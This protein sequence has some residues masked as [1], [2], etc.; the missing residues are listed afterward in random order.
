MNSCRK[1]GASL[2]YQTHGKGLYSATQG[3]DG[4]YHVRVMDCILYMDMHHSW[5]FINSMH[6][7]TGNVSV[8]GDE[9]TNVAAL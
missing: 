3:V 2:L 4:V 5:V 7:L 8:L 9:D 1:P 6:S